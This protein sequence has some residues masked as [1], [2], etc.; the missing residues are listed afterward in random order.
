MPE[1]SSIKFKKSLMNTPYKNNLEYWKDQFHCIEFLIAEY[2]LCRKSSDLSARRAKILE[3]FSA[4]QNYVNSRLNASD[5]NLEIRASRFKKSGNFNDLEWFFISIATMQK[6]DVNH[7]AL[8][9]KLDDSGF[10]SYNA[11]LKLYFLEHEVENIPDFYNLRASVAQKLKIYFE[12][13]DKVQ[14]NEQLFCDIVSESNQTPQNG[15]DFRLPQQP[16]KNGIRTVIADDMC[17]FVKKNNE[18]NQKIFYYIYGEYGIG[19]QHLINNVCDKLQKQLVCIDCLVAKNNCKEFISIIKSA[20]CNAVAS[21]SFIH[22]KNAETLVHEGEFE[23][24]Y[25]PLIFEHACNCADCVFISGV[26]KAKMPPKFYELNGIEVELPELNGTES[27]QMWHESAGSDVAF[28][29]I[30]F[31]DL[32]NK[33]TLTPGQIINAAKQAKNSCVWKNS[34]TIT[35]AGVTEAIYNQI[36]EKLSDKTTLIKAKYTWNDI[37]LPEKQKSIIMQACNQIKYKHIVY[38]NW[39][40][41]DS[42]LYGRGLSMLFSGPSGTGKTM[43]A[44]VV[45][46]ELGLEIYRVDLSQVVSKW[47]GETEKNIGEIFDSAQRSN[48]VLLFDEMDALFAK[49]TEV[50]DSHDKSANLETSYLLQKIE[51]YSGITIMTTNFIQNIDQ[52]FFR[53]ISYVVNFNLPGVELRKK[54]WIKM[55]PKQAPM[56]KNIDFDFLANNFA[57][58][59][60]NI[61]NVVITSTFMAAA[62]GTNITMSHILKALEYEITKQ[63]KMISKSDFGKYAYLI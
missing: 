1:N 63:G 20:C 37:V 44:Q 48:V 58:A 27:V 33:F 35:V 29:D 42:F 49:R 2:I 5:N 53:R 18:K 23:P 40:L 52:A 21:G 22:F 17:N 15:L 36:T 30:N 6:T 56:D 3:Q 32:A 14:I 13:D 61:K 47:I 60:G 12:D 62:E 16:Q 25:I 19:K 54:M 28:K 59:G 10:L 43:A 51:E 45:A 7:A 41:K 46:S 9:Q 26:V 24:E 57:I 38:D 31:Q 4:L 39:G 55:Y 50:T 11:V 8:L 34:K